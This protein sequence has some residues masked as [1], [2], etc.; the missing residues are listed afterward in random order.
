[1]TLTTTEIILIGIVTTAILLIL[2]N[3]IR[4]DVVAIMVLLA[5]PLS[6]V[7]TVEQAFSGFSRGVIFT[8][9]GLFI[10]SHAL[11]ETGVIAWLAERL[12][13]LG[14]GRETRLLLIIMGAGAVLALFMNIIAAGAVLLPVAVTVARDSNVR[15]SKLLIPLSYGTLV[16]GT[17]T[18]FATA[19]IVISGILV[20]QELRA[21]TFSDFLPT[22]IMIII[23]GV[24]YMLLIGRKLLP[25]REGM[26]GS[27]SSR[28]LA[29]TLYDAYQLQERLWEMRVLPGSRLAGVT[30][31]D[32]D[33][34][35][36]LGLSVLAIWR[37]GS[38]MLTLSPDDD[39]EVGDYLLVLGREERVREL[40]MWGLTLGRDDGDLHTPSHDYS[41][42]LTEVII[43]PRSTIVGKTLKE[44][45][46]RGKF[47][48]TA[49]ALWREGRS[50]RTDVGTFPLEVGDAVLMVGSAKHIR[51]LQRERDFIVLTSSHT[52]QPPAPQKG[53]WAAAIMAAVIGLSVFNIL[54]T[55]EA[56]LMGAVAMVLTGCLN[57]DEAYR[58]INWRVI[59][60]I[61][62]MTPISIALIDTGLADRLGQI[63]VDIA[64]PF[65]GLALIA[66]LF[67]LTMSITQVLSGQ[68]T[69]IIVGPIAVAAALSMGVDP[70]AVAVAT[71]T[72]CSSGFLIPTAHP[73][74][75][76]MMG[77]GGYVPADFLKVGAG[78]TLVTF[79]ALMLGM[80]V[81]WGVR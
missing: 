8:L 29:R 40:L 50:Y 22:G 32:S 15:A 61:A 80:I 25:D 58:G 36:K 12:T 74:N 78:M 75:A 34:G 79:A 45:G 60:L 2:S 73:V 17:A 55:A 64:S 4:S 39:I 52:A 13:R 10:I 21:L 57:M 46:F 5:L 42:D 3:R 76:L 38:A 69:A 31:A 14:G 56:M 70:H 49:V 71:A 37:G 35:E 20:D 68:V 48:L 62:G 9:I 16:G 28:N 67:L 23:A 43:P 27:P 26:G 65:G 30:L 66:G 11:E 81:V 44:I 33:I 51:T 41:V 24:V 19:N 7:L 54:P 1:M 72:A 47:G 63:V 53:G 6:G 77:P 59:F 18:I